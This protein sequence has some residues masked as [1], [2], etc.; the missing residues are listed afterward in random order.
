[1]IDTL[2][3]IELVSIINF[4]ITIGM[5]YIG[6]LYI[7]RYEKNYRWTAYG[8]YFL[9]LRFFVDLLLVAFVPTHDFFN[10]IPRVMGLIGV[11]IIV[12]AVTGKFE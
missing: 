1:M 11:L 4:V 2:L 9:A 8:L 12:L 7:R 10:I 3:A 6:T 5:I